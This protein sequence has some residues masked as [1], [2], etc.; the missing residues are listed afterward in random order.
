MM[1]AARSRSFRSRLFQS[2]LEFRQHGPLLVGVQPHRRPLFR[3]IQTDKRVL[4]KQLIRSFSNE[5]NGRI[6]H[7]GKEKRVVYHY[8]LKKKQS[9]GE[10]QKEKQIFGQ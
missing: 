6:Y 5:L 9:E 2:A 8:K 3:P 10:K 4:V 1:F 7:G